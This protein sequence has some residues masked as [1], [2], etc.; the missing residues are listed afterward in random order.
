MN[1]ERPDFAD[2]EAPP[3]EDEPPVEEHG[4]EPEEEYDPADLMLAGAF[5]SA[6]QDHLL[7]LVG[8]QWWRYDAAGRWVYAGKEIA[9]AEVQ[10]F[11]LDYRDRR[12]RRPTITPARIRNVMFLAKSLMGPHALE[13]FAEHPHWIAFRNGVLDVMTKQFFAHDPTHYLTAVLPYDYNPEADCPEFRNFL[14][15]AMAGP[16]GAPVE[17]WC[18]GI[19]EWLGYCMI[20]DNR[21]Q[22]DIIRPAACGRR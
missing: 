13:I 9:E 16:D 19:L 21:A 17:E 4:D 22:S 14:A 11:L 2:G 8:D 6:R 1:D 10:Y 12:R 20:P 5:A 15:E 18:Q 7:Y 3:P